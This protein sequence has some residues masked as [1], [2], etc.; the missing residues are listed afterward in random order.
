MATIMQRLVLPVLSVREIRD[1]V[2]L[3]TF[4]AETTGEP[5]VDRINSPC[6]DEKRRLKK[7]K[8]LLGRESPTDCLTV[9]MLVS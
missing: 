3:G 9:W 1:A 4:D 7:G 5:G 8:G 2:R 6:W